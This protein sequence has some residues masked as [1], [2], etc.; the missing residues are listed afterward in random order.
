MGLAVNAY[1]DQIIFIVNNID[2]E[3][4][5]DVSNLD[6]EKISEAFGAEPT[7]EQRKLLTAI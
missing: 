6:V 7:L 5:F 3:F 1:I 4:S 2:D